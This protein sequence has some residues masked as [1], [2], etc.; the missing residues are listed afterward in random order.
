[1]KISYHIDGKI[2]RHYLL[3][4][5]KL[6]KYIKIHPYTKYHDIKINIKYSFHKNNLHFLD[7]FYILTIKCK[8]C[9]LYYH[10]MIVKWLYDPYITIINNPERTYIRKY[11]SMITKKISSYKM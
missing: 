8:N 2:Y 5:R 11:L 1:M 10:G 9:D 4:R 7:D 6:T 3:N